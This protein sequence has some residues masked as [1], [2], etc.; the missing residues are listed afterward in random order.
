IEKIKQNNIL[1]I[2]DEVMTGFCRTGTYFALDQLDIVPD[3][4]CVSKGITGGFLPLGLTIT[5]QAI[6]EAF[7]SDDFST[8]FI[9]GHSYTANPLACQAAITSLE[10]LTDPACQEAIQKINKAHKEGIE[11]LKSSCSLVKKTRIKGTIS[12]FDLDLEKQQML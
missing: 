9:H 1:V 12:A 10:L 8:A 11:Y 7:L 5:T 3:F 2:F 4:L 6:Y